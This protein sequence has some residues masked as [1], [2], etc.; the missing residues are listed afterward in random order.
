MNK[1]LDGNSY[2]SVG[3][4][5]LDNYAD[6]YGAD[7]LYKIALRHELPKS[8]ISRI[9]NKLNMLN[10]E[11]IPKKEAKQLLAAAPDSI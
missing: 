9:I 2:P 10:P 7:T 5:M 4:A 11:Y 6:L 3:K 8:Y 1:Y